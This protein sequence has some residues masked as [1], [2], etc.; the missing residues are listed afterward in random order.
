MLSRGAA[1]CVDSVDLRTLTSL[2]LSTCT[3]P[4]I[5]GFL[6][7]SY[8]TNRTTIAHVIQQPHQLTK[9]RLSSR[10]SA[11]TWYHLAPIQSM[12]TP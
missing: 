7:R 6:H 10:A 3:I 2:L 11:K 9:S 5:V 4:W 1:S 8:R 12:E